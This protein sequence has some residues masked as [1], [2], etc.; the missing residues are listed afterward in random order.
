MGIR[1]HE[2][3][4]QAH[5][6]SACLCLCL[7]HG[8]AWQGK[9]NGAQAVPLSRLD[10]QDIRGV[11][12]PVLRAVAVD[13][14]EVADAQVRLLLAQAVDAREHRGREGVAVVEDGVV[15]DARPHRPAPLVARVV[16][17][18]VAVKCARAI[19]VEGLQPDVRIRDD[20]PAL[21][22]E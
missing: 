10:H 3:K 1:K 6:L 8:M 20:S 12:A 4:Q 19:D 22:F 17:G 15:A 14:D 18:G 5:E 13:G 11:G 16:E 9:G 21:V 2:R 7:W